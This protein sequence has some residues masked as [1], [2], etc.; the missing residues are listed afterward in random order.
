MEHYK[1]LSLTT[2]SDVMS[3]MVIDRGVDGVVITI[4]I[5]TKSGDVKSCS[6]CLDDQQEN[7]LLNFI[8]K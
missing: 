2:I 5:K 4:Y 1:G 7:A 3:S 8:S 6:I